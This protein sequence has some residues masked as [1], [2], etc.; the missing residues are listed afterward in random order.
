M[1]KNSAAVVTPFGDFL[2]KYG[3]KQSALSRSTAMSQPKISML[4]NDVKSFANLSRWEIYLLADALRLNEAT[5][6]YWVDMC[7]TRVATEP[8]S[9]SYRL[10]G[11]ITEEMYRKARRD[12]DLTPM[13]KLLR[14]SGISLDEFLERAV[15]ELA[16]SGGRERLLLLINTPWFDKKQ[17]G[18]PT[19]DEVRAFA[20]ALKMTTTE[21]VRR[22]TD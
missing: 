17:T 9:D 4:A 1:S 2:N 5:V 14:E 19:K 20:K 8:K 16:M 10:P 11:K 22:L 15:K 7:I 3:I 6:E 13:K 21:L 18:V 12:D